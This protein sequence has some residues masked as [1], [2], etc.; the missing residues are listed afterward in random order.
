[1][2]RKYNKTT[3]QILLRYGIQNNC[4]VLPKSKT[5][6]RIEENFDIFDFDIDKNDIKSIDS[7]SN[8]DNQR[9]FAWDP[10]KIA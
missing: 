7:I 8:Q 9:K 10:S 1:M 3:A 6:T 5:L 2:T 4:I